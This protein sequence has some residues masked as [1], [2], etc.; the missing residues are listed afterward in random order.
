MWLSGLHYP[1]AYVTALIQATCRTKGWP[2]DKST[3]YTVVTKFMDEKE[4]KSKP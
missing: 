4:I 3:T 2:L 1:G